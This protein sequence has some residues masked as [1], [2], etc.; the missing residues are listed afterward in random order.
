VLG[1]LSIRGIDREKKLGR[2]S[3]ARSCMALL[4]MEGVGIL[5]Q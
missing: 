1:V 2:K 3:G 5:L 4:A